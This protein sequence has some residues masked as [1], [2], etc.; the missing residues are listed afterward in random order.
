MRETNERML[1]KSENNKN[2][3]HALDHF[4]VWET[5][6]INKNNTIQ[7]ISTF[8]ATMKQTKNTFMDRFCL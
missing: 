4:R 5:F 1:I 3:P 2:R 8:D 6:R 7:G